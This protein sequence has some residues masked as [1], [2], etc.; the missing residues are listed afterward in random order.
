M[1]GWRDSLEEV[2]SVSFEEG[3]L[4]WEWLPFEEKI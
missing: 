4:D 3:L 2:A 1:E